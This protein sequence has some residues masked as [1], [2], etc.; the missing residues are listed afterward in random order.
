MEKNFNYKACSNPNAIH[1]ELKISALFLKISATKRVQLLRHS[2]QK[3]LYN[4]L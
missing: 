4:N 1:K 3:P 2:N